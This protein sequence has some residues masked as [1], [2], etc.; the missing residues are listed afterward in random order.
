M[1]SGTECTCELLLLLAP[2]ET[3]LLCVTLKDYPIEQIWHCKPI[4]AQ[5]DIT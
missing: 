1:G 4:I 2:N 3:L 5:S